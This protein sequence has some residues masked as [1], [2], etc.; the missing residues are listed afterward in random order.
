V[1]RTT[2]RLGASLRRA[3]YVWLTLT[4]LLYFA[5]E[6][7]VAATVTRPSDASTPVALA[8]AVVMALAAFWAAVLVPRHM[9][10]KLRLKM[11]EDEIAL[12]RWFYT[13]TPLLVGIVAVALGGQSWAFVLGFLVSVALTIQ[14]ART[15]S[16]SSPA[17]LA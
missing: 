13:A 8:A 10:P 14:L 17:E 12:I 2:E 4:I 6:S 7:P 9:V 15:I 11:S 5:I 16:Q 3:P 1:K